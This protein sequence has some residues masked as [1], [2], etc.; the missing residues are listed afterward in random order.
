MKHTHRRMSAAAAGLL[1][2]G[3]L[4]LAS[5]EPAHGDFRD[6][7]DTAADMVRGA[8]RLERQPLIAVTAADKRLVAVGSR[9]LIAL[10]DDFGKTWRQAASPVQSDLVAVDFVSAGQG[11][12]AGHDGVVLAT[13]D[14]GLSWSKQL[15][16]RAALKT[17]LPYYQARVD[18][19]QGD[20]QQYL[21]QVHKNTDGD[22]SLPYLSVAFDSATHGYAVGAFGMIATTDDGGRSWL[23]AW[24]LIDNPQQLNLNSVRRI[25][26]AYY[27]AGEQG[28]V[29]RQ[30]PASGRFLPVTTGYAGSFFDLAGDADYLLA[31]GLR[32]T[33]YRSAD[34]G[35]SWSKVDAGSAATIY[36]GTVLADGTAI[37]VTEA[38]EVLLGRDHGQSFSRAP[39]AVMSYAASVLAVPGGGLVLAGPG[40]IQ[41]ARLDAAQ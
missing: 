29:F 17:F 34:H 35:A 25:G 12:A 26:G 23:P 15:D 7:L 32:G 24:H 1:L 11:W 13:Q 33:V 36:T 20:Y 28:T 22:N 5:D 14:G 2:I 6:P 16:F 31:F 39:T 8:L 40:G 21:D 38:G 37:L 41:V 27:I 3:G 19:G 4:A 10:S 9:G 18:G 30:A